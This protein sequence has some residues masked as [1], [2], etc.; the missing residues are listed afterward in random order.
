MKKIMLAALLAVMTAVSPVGLIKSMAAEP[1][2]AVVSET[3]N[4]EEETEPAEEILAETEELPE[5]ILPQF[6]PLPTELYVEQQKNNT[7]TLASSVMMLRA[8]IY[9]NDRYIWPFVE[10]EYVRPDAWKEGAGLYH[11]W[12]YS[13]GDSK[14]TVARAEVPGMTAEELKALLDSHPEGIVIYDRGDEE[15]SPHAVFAT[16]YEED[17][18]YCADPAKGYSGERIALASSLIGARYEELQENVLSTIDAYWYISDHSF[19]TG[20]DIVPLPCKNSCKLKN[21]GVY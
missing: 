10:E 17:I 6:V 2:E 9:L 16:D 12:S 3:E 1:T 5:E 14:L 15:H 8:E 21:G 11:S 13:I 18:F 19:L 7:C 4:L 20:D